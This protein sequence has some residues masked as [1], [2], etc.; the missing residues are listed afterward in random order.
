VCVCVCVGGEVWVFGG[1]R[2]GTTAGACQCDMRHATS[3]LQPHTHHPCSANARATRPSA[4]LQRLADKL[5]LQLH[6]LAHQPV[7][8]AL[9]QR[10]AQVA[11]RV[12][13]VR[14]LWRVCVCVCG[15][16]SVC[17]VRAGC[18]WVC[19]RRT[20]AC[21]GQ[22][23]QWCSDVQRPSASVKPGVQAYRQGC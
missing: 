7:H 13:S 20:A 18:E 2:A 21:A 6:R 14:S 22:C 16:C 4:H 5:L 17:V 8:L 9:G 12:W 19:A 11:A 10:V 15:V 1:T 3:R 23:V